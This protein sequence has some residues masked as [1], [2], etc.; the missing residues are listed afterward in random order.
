M[1]P[2]LI[3]L[4]ELHDREAAT[5]AQ[6][7]LA[8]LQSHR[9]CGS[10]VRADVAFTVPGVLAIVQVDF[11]PTEPDVDSRVWVVGGDLPAAYLAWEVG[12]SWQDALRGYVEEMRLW[13]R[14]AADGRSVDGLIPVNVPPTRQ[15][16]EMLVTRLA[17]LEREFLSAGPDDYETAR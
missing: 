7:G 3:P 16:A 13:A 11:A 1:P 12:D 6:H 9:W 10:V 14:A 17:F 15:Y 4:A 8:Y 5:A 2:A